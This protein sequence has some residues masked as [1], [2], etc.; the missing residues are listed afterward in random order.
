MGEIRISS[1]AKINLSIDVKGVLES[2]MHKVDMI[3]Q[4]ISFHDDVNIIYEEDEKLQK[5]DITI[6]LKTNKAYLPVDE[7]NTA[8]KAAALMIERYGAKKAGGTIKIDVLKRIPVAAGMAG[9]SGNGAAVIHGLNALWKLKL[10]LKELCA[11]G[12]E[13]GSDVPFCIMG[14]AK[15]NYVLPNAIRKDALAGSC[16]RATGTGIEMN[17]IKGIKTFLVIAKPPISVSTKQVYQGIDSCTINKRPDNDQLIID[18]QTH[19]TVEIFKNCINVL[20]EY[21]LEAYPE[22]RKLKEKI[23]CFKSYPLVLM[24]GSGPT[25]F[26]ICRNIDEAREL[27]QELRNQGYEAYWTKTTK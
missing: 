12:A 3:M 4:Q 22:V 6:E 11:L 19:N 5:G 15:N 9:G 25:V 23:K 17:P 13:I 18:L 2:G 10:S 26:T 20:E 7:K 8:Y 16:A 1:Y 14:Q 27:S 24:S 21:T